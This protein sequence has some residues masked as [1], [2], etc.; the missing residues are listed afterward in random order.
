MA[1]D[2]VSRGAEFM[3]Y[4]QPIGD[5]RR[6]VDRRCSGRLSRRGFGMITPVYPGVQGDMILGAFYITNR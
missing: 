4:I 6:T 3:A 1:Q 2:R 5:G